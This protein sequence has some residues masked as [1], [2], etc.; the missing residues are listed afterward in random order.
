MATVLASVD[1]RHSGVASAVSNAMSRLG[2]MIAVAALPLAAGLSGTAFQ[3]PARMA[4]GFPVAMTIATGV[5]FAA[6]LS[7]PPP[8][9]NKS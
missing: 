2:Q 5:S 4:A 9:A 7:H 8:T 6:A 1:A 3:D